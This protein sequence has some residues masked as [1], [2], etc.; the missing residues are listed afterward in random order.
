[1]RF[2]HKIILFISLIIGFDV[3]AYL[4]YG[5]G[6]DTCNWTTDT[7]LTK[8][9]WNCS[10]LTIG[11]NI[12]IT[13]S[14][15]VTSAIQIRVQGD[16]T[17]AGDIVVSAS[18]TQA[19][20]GGTAGGDCTAG[21]ICT[22][23]DGAGSSTGIGKGGERGTGAGGL[24]GNGGGGG[25]AGFAVA[26][27][28]GSAGIAGGGTPGSLGTGGSAFAS[29]GT[30]N[31]TLIGGVGGGAGGSGDNGLGTIGS[32]GDGGHGSGSIAIIS[33]G[34]ILLTA[35]AS[36][37]AN[38]STGS[39]GGSNGGVT[40]GNG[41]AGSGGVIYLVTKGTLTATTGVTINISGGVANTTPGRAAGG[42][43]SDGLFRVDTSD[44]TYT[45]NFGATSPGLTSTTPSGISDPLASGSSGGGDSSTPT[46]NSGSNTS[47][48]DNIDYDSE[49]D[50]SCSYRQDK[51]FE[52]EQ[53]IMTYLS[54][55]L[56]FLIA[57]S[58]FKSYKFGR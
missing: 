53:F 6:S 12:N 32:G 38:G 20:P 18:A 45:G 27:S 57:S 52:L 28:D 3:N 15:T 48:V 55:F 43:G 16:T 7:I 30:I 19:G 58:L 34:N 2:Y 17:I 33:K 25:G 40:G 23:Q 29:L 41:G 36:I 31:S 42:A 1:M 11:T 47:T 56:G 49:I 9:V 39:D 21:A 5:D 50:P 4:S 46:D 24:A 10:S 22:L 8:A 37:T 26:G 44:G 35:D 51:S 54:L 13:V 14:N